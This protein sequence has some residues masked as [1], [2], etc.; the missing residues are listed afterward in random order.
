MWPDAEAR[1]TASE[2]MP[3]GLLRGTAARPEGNEMPPILRPL[4][5]QEFV[6]ELKTA[7][8]RVAVL[9][10]MNKAIQDAVDR[11]ARLS[12]FSEGLDRSTDIGDVGRLLFEEMRGILPSEVL[13]LAL[14]KTA[15]QGFEAAGVT[16]PE[17]T[18]AALREMEA[19]T[20]SGVFGWV[21][22]LRRPILVQ[23]VHLTTNLVLVPLATVRRVVGMLMVGTSLSSDAVEQQHL[24]LAAVVARQAAECIDNL[25][26]AEEM[27]Q[28]SEARRLVQE[29]A[30][31]RRVADL[32]LLVETAGS[33][34]A[35]LD[36]RAAMGHLVGACCRH[37]G[38]QSVAVSVLT[39]DGRLVPAAH[40]GRPQ[41]CEMVG[42]P[43]DPEGC[44]LHWIVAHQ[45]PLL[46]PDI[47][48]GVPMAGSPLLAGGECGAFSGVPLVARDRVVGVLSVMTDEPR[49]FAAEEMALLTGLAAQG[50]LAL[51]NVRLFADVQG[52]MEEQQRS[53]A[54][55]VQSSHMASVGL[56]AGGVAHD[57]NNPLCIISNHLQ[58]LKL[59]RE[60]LPMELT[61]VLG[62]I[63]TSVQ[64]IAGSI[65]ALLEYA[66]CQ[67]GEHQAT[68][69][70]EAVRRILILLQY[71]PLCRRLRVE[72]ALTPGLPAVDLD[73]G[74]WDQVMLELVTN[75]REAMTEGGVVRISTREGTEGDDWVE[76]VVEDDG[77]GIDPEDLPRL[78]D[79][80]FTTRQ[81][82]RGMGVGLKMCRDIIQE[83][84]GRLRLESDGRS[85]TRVVIGLREASAGADPAA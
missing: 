58:L 47:R 74:A 80:F 50:A 51:E 4:I 44:P 8:R 6:E 9:E 42:D 66:R 45:Q 22:G 38:V 78:F 76:V 25:W 63:E 54:R 84:G 2:G 77:P 57:I 72:T 37:L 60:P 82:K 29:A 17:S 85:G 68:D 41:V 40:V 64:R 5:G 46:I 12:A 31:A 71:H 65:E 53:M 23:A 75:A 73:R 26:L 18:E 48:A 35:R 67:P 56:L 49:E 30:I 20:A 11:V 3:S 24:T 79:P 19:Q 39:P 28:E 27:R 34:S 55:L 13:L 1:R 43:H 36:Q 62:S 81:A 14:A 33:F 7:R 10:E 59:R 83:H 32:G 21:V 15:D 61:G 16:P 70:N 52:R 69:I